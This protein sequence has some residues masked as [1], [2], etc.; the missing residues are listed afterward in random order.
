MCSVVTAGQHGVALRDMGGEGSCRIC[1]WSHCDMK[2]ASQW[3][4][5]FILRQ[6]HQGLMN[7]LSKISLYPL[8]CT[9][10]YATCLL[11]HV[12]LVLMRLAVTRE[13]LGSSLY[14]NNYQSRFDFLRF[15]S[16]FIVHYFCCHLFLF[17]Q[18]F[19]SKSA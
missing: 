14:C 15:T 4:E 9:C 5:A 6:Y 7:Q 17:Q 16:D 19:N 12:V 3:A 2:C 11:E 13:I 10:V 18:Q 1:T 8:V